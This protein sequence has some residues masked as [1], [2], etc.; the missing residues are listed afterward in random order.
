MKKYI[1]LVII[2]GM[3]FSLI[4]CSNN[5]KTNN[6][7]GTDVTD[8][9]D[10]GGTT[11][12]NTTG[13]PDLANLK[14]GEYTAQGDKREQGSEEATVVIDGGKITDITLRRL[15]KQGNEVDYDKWTGE[16]IDGKTYPNLKQ[17]RIDMAN[18]MIEAQSYDVDTIAGATQSCES[19]KLAVKRALEQAAQ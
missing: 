18:K 3:L 19:W 5:N 15:D 6:Q 14:D 12:D 1:C 16:E 10:N 11:T 8:T 17:Y 4:G 13:E 7:G 2:M 9:T